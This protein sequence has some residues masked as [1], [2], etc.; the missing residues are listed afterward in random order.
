MPRIEVVEHIQAPPARVW[1]LFSDIRRGPEWV[2]VMEDVVH[3]SE[4][5]VRRGTVYRERS[6]IGPMRSRLE[7]SRRR[8]QAAGE[9]TSGASS[10]ESRETP[11]GR[12][13]KTEDPRRGSKK[14]R[15]GR[16]V[17]KNEHEIVID[18]PA[19]RVFRFVADLG[20]WPRWHG[21][22]HEM[23]K[24][25]Q[26]PVGVGTTWEASGQVQGQRI[27][28]TVEVTEY[29]PSRRFGIK[30]T[31]GPIEARQTFVC[32][33]VAGGTRLAMVL[34]LS[35]ADLAAPARQQWDNDLPIL[36]KLLEGQAQG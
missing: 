30:T 3:V 35:D 5:P 23:E 8:S 15:E 11:H 10:R 29:E 14:E 22:G 20:T 21:S 12:T 34:E 13:P 4:E 26:G 36:K 27:A 9:S 25:T 2:S 31:S 7:A 18:C 6:T 33:H 32:E 1:D 17:V 16:A 19:E 24:T 28:V